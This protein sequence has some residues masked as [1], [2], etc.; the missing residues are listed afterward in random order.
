MSLDNLPFNWFDIVLT[1]V[2]VMGVFRGRKRGMSEELMTVLLWLAIVVTSSVAYE[3]IGDWLASVSLF[4]RLMCY[5]TAYLVTAA[6]VSLAFL[7]FKRAFRGKLVGS[8][9]FGKAEYYLGMPAGMVRFGCVLLAGLAL[10]NAPFYTRAEIQAYKDYQM[11]NFDNEFFPGLQTLQANVFEKS[12]TGPPI[13]KYL[14]FL[15]IKPTTSTGGKQLK[16]SEWTMP[17]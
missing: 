2:L 10:L 8:D 17:K 15:L 3:P 14:G 7:L 4:S 16:Q 12:L 5:V 9:A 13:K 11:K 6:C 1:M